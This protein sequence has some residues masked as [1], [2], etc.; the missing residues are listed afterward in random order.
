M[1]GGVTDKR[2]KITKNQGTKQRRTHKMSL[3]V[4]RFSWSRAIASGPF[5]R[6]VVLMQPEPAASFHPHGR[7]RAA[8]PRGSAIRAGSQHEP[9]RRMRTAI[10]GGS[11]SRPAT[12]RTTTR[13]RSGRTRCPIRWSSPTASRSRTRRRGRASAGRRSFG[14]TR[15]EIFGRIPANDAE[16]HL[17]VT[18]PIVRARDGAADR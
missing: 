17:A 1:A 16:G 15:A 2:T 13:A 5:H 14:S 7:H 8:R 4:L 12:C 11:R 18:R 6:D 9:W 3:G 10:R